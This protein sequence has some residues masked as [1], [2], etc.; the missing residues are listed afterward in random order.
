MYSV[1]RNIFKIPDL[2][3]RIFFTLAM[4]VVV[5]LGYYIA[6]PGIDHDVL[7]ALMS[8]DNGLL[9]MLSML[10]G[11]GL[12]SASIFTLGVGPYIQASIMIQILSMDVVPAFTRWAKEGEL[13]RRKTAQVT[14]Y[15]ALVLAAIQAIG[16][17]YSGSKYFGVGSL[18]KVS[19]FWSYLLVAVVV[20]CGTSIV[21]W[22]GDQITDKGIGNGIS[23]IILSG[24]LVKSPQQIGMIW[25]KWVVSGQTFEGILKMGLLILLATAVIISVIYVQQGVRKIP[26]QYTQRVIG[27][28]ICTGQSTHI[29][30]KL[31]SAGVTPVI[32]ASMLITAI[33]NIAYFFNTNFIGKWF[34]ETFSMGSFSYLLIESLLIIGFSYFY[35]FAQL[36]PVQLVDQ[37]K[38]NGGFI[39]SIRPG[40]KTL[41][42]LTKVLNR[43]TAVGAIFL[44]VIVVLPHV[45]AWFAGEEM[46]FLAIGGT[47]LLIVIGVALEVMKMVEGRL[48]RRHYKGFMHK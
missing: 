48:M 39:P 27:N 9:G 8:K 24:I 44:C 7:K 28:K 47:G 26:V 12:L 40:Q 25:S 32:L 19:S 15:V 35:T 36:N 45:V 10:S 17:L 43:L 21:M 34:S 5:R 16:L 14:R 38:K 23:L 18:L 1:I 11:G 22:L 3:K 41:V 20:T 31:N 6:V 29:P 2:R 30:L 33:T 13:G 37:L 42:Y 46:K 4:L